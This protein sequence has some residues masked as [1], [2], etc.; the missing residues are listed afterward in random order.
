MHSLLILFTHFTR[1]A[2]PECRLRVTMPLA[3]Q[4]KT[5]PYE[6]NYKLGVQ[7]LPPNPALNNNLQR[8][9]PLPPTVFSDEFTT[10]SRSFKDGSDPVWTSL[11]KNDYT[12][13]AL[14]YYSS[15][16]VTTED[17]RLK[18]RTR[19]KEKTFKALDEK[20]RK[21][22]RE[23]KYYEVRCSLSLSPPRVLV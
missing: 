16:A 1:R 11:D 18:I 7:F 6:S 13:A 9:R 23:T 12:N 2:L 20:T 4:P 21:F 8:P 17:G 15:D 19:R 3:R 10:P 22:G 5:P 14:H